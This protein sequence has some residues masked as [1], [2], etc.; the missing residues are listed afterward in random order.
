MKEIKAIIQP[1]ML[2]KVLD[3]LHEVE[4]LP[5]CT[6]SEVKGYGRGPAPGEPSEERSYE[7]ADRMKIEIIVPDRMVEKVVDTIRKNAHTGNRGDGKIFVIETVD[8][9]AIR[10]NKPGE[11]AI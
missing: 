3:A 6:V 10:T 9:V 4:N 11:E 1:L 7:S 8:A 5:G 2:D